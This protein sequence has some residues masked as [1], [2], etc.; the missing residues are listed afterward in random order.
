MRNALVVLV[1]ALGIGFATSAFA[2]EE[3][4]VYP[5]MKPCCEFTCLELD[6]DCDCCCDANE[7]L[8][9]E[10]LDY[11]E[12]VLGTGVFDAGWC[13]PCGPYFT[14][15][16]KAVNSGD[17]CMIRF[18]KADED[19]SCFWLSLKVLCEDPCTCGKWRMAWKGDVWCWTPVKE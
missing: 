15:L 4:V 19:C 18:V 5:C 12:N 6:T 10:F 17:V 2:A 9:V 3:M 14:K 13:G 8:T 11:E 1:L 16:D 7:P